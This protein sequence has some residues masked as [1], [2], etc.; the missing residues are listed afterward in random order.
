MNSKDVFFKLLDATMLM[1][2]LGAVFVTIGL[3]V[4][5]EQAS[6]LGSTLFFA[7]EEPTIRTVFSGGLFVCFFLLPMVL[8]AYMLALVFEKLFCKT[9]S[10][11]KKYS[12]EKYK[13]H[14]AF[15]IL[16]G[17]LVAAVFM[18]Y[19]IKLSNFFKP[20]IDDNFLVKEIVLFEGNFLISEDE[21]LKF[22]YKYNDTIY[23]KRVKNDAISYVAINFDAIKHLE[24]EGKKEN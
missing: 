10:R 18:P 8:I 15:I 22:V 9:T 3:L 12:K 7:R 21:T 2:I 5:I 19:I 11:L 4:D 13:E 1:A 17:V 23:F 16:L 24:V 20:P 6:R 14:P